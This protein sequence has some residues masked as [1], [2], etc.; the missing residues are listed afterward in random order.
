M[1][2]TLRIMYRR[3]VWDYFHRCYIIQYP[4]LIWSRNSAW[5]DCENVCFRKAH[6]GDFWGYTFEPEKAAER[7]LKYG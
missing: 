7:N 5:K 6:N 4:R 2:N 1:V 3:P